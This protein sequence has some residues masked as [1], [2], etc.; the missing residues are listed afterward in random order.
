MLGQYC[1][2]PQRPDGLIPRRPLRIE[3]VP[4]AGAGPW[5][6]TGRFMWPFGTGSSSSYGV[7]PSGEWT[8]DRG[9]RIWLPGR[10]VGLVEY[11]EQMVGKLMAAVCSADDRWWMTLS[12]AWLPPTG[13][14]LA[15]ARRCWRS[16]GARDPPRPSS[17]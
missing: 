8:N 4:P 16:N 14:W 12:R 11:D 9:D 10:Q 3:F 1:L 15:A 7:I 5:R 2:G 17:R 6:M 13:A